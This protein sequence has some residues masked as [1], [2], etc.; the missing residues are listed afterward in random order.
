M[1]DSLLIVESPTKEKTIAKFLGKEFQV[2]S[3]YGHVRDLPPRA[4]GVDVEHNFEP[5]YVTLPQAKKLLPELTRQAKSAKQVFLATD[6]DR[7]GEA[8]AWH[9]TQILKIPHE[10][11]K[12]ITFHE[13]TPEAIREAV[14]HPR[15]IDGR[16]VHAQQARRILDR[17]VGYQLSPLLW[18]KVR[19]GLSA[20]RVQSA[21]VRL[22]CDREDEIS[23]FIPQEYWTLAARL[24]KRSGEEFLAD[25]L[26]KIVKRGGPSKEGLALGADWKLEKFDRL[27]LKN[28]QQIDEIIQACRDKRFQVVAVERKDRR[29]APQAP[30]NTASL[31][32]DSSHVLG[33]RAQ[34]T[35]VIAQQ[36]YEGITLGGGGPVGLITY[37]RTDSV[38]VAKPAQEEAARYIREKFGANFIPPKS[39]VFKT[40]TKGAQEAHEAIRPTSVYREPEAVKSFLSP[41]QFKLYRLIWERFVASQMTD[42]VYDTV[43]AD[44]E[45]GSYLFRA[46]GRTLRFKGFLAVHN[47]LDSDEASPQLPPLSV[48][49][50]LN[51]KEF[52][53]GQHYTDPPPR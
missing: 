8:I 27:D 48:G 49:E 4:L 33:Y 20:G 39:R 16:L 47:T 30:Y 5:R 35:M 14:D 19:R 45:A 41:E 21:V 1:S 3:S 28:K 12:R 11:I 32:Q 38:S 46:N 22:I 6:F 18:K 15:T 50:T 13:I 40:K 10:K 52:I 29:R 42:A 51:F 34:R 44:I 7:E 37:M 31:Q 17:L 26:A 53:P 24:A 9:L 43:A 36:L 25:I 2:K 23:K